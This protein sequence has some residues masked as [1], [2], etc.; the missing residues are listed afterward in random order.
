VVVVVVRD[1]GVLVQVSTP[2]FR[3]RAIT[4]R[5]HARTNVAL[6]PKSPHVDMQLWI[7]VSHAEMQVSR[8]VAPSASRPIA[9]AATIANTS[10]HAVAQPLTT[11]P[12]LAIGRG[13]AGYRIAWGRR[14][15]AVHERATEALGIEAQRLA[16][17]HEG[18]RPG[19]ILRREPAL[20]VV[21]QPASPS[22]RSIL[23]SPEL[24]DGVAQDGDHEAL[25][26]ARGRRVAGRI[27]PKGARSPVPLAEVRVRP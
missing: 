25:L 5:R 12:A 17:A 10:K 24:H 20:D 21:E 9:L 15:G 19:V 13:R 23:E 7:S 16:D 3:Q 1:D 11:P 8:V 27:D 14:S 18:E 2:R 6:V 4:A 22:I 26:A